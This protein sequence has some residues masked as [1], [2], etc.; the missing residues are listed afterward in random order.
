[1]SP[2]HA[3]PT[4]LPRGVLLLLAVLLAA[5]ASASA[6]AQS[7]ARYAPANPAAYLPNSI[8]AGGPAV[9]HRDGFTYVAIWRAFGDYVPHISRTDEATGLSE[10]AP[11]PGATAAPALPD[12]RLDGHY[13]IEMKLD[14]AGYIHAVATTHG[15]AFRYWRSNQPAS[16]AAGFTELTTDPALGIPQYALG[17]TYPKLL[18]DNNGVLFLVLRVEINTRDPDQ[19]ERGVA[20][21][22][23]DV[24]TGRWTA[25]GDYAFAHPAAV[26]GA[27]TLAGK[28]I[29]WEWAG[30]TP[31]L[32]YQGFS[33]N[34]SFDPQ[35]RLHFTVTTLDRFPD[36]DLPGGN[37]DTL[38]YARSD[39]GGDTW[40]RSDGT[41]ITRL[42][43]RGRAGLPDSAEIVYQGDPA[44]SEG[45]V[46]LQTQIVA[47]RADGLLIGCDYAASRTPAGWL[48]APAADALTAGR[49]ASRHLLGTD[50]RLHT[51]RAPISGGGNLRILDSVASD[52]A[53]QI[54]S[55]LPMP[56][57][58]GGDAP[59]FRRTGLLYGTLA[60]TLYARLALTPGW[61]Q[62]ALGSPGGHGYSTALAPGTFRIRS[63]GGSAA[64]SSDLGRFT[65]QT[66]SGDGVL[67]ARLDS[68][69][70]AS[71]A[72]AG[73]AFRENNNADARS[74][75]LRADASGFRFLVR[76]AASAVALP[77]GDALAPFSGS[78][79]PWLRLTRAGS[80]LSA[81]ASADGQTWTL[82][83]SVTL[84][85]PTDLLAGPVVS[86]GSA[87]P[88]DFAFSRVG[89][90]GLRNVAFGKPAAQSSNYYDLGAG[91][92]TDG[93]TDGNLANGSVAMTYNTDASYFWRVDLLEPATVR[94]LR[95]FK[96]TDGARDGQ[97]NNAN[98][99]LL[100][101]AGAALWTGSIP[102]GTL[103][104]PFTLTPAGTAGVPGVRFVE[105]LRSSQTALAELEVMGTDSLPLPASDLV[106]PATPAGLAVA[107]VNA[108]TVTLSWQPSASADVA[109]YVLQR[110][111][112]ASGP[113]VA[114]AADIFLPRYADTGR[115]ASVSAWHYR[116]AACDHAGNR[117]AFSSPVA[118]TLRDR[119]PPSPPVI[120]TYQPTD[121]GATLGWTDLAP[122]A[123][124]SHW[125]LVR[126]DRAGRETV[127]LARSTA[128]TY[129]WTAP[130]PG[131]YAEFFL[132]AY[133][134][135][136]NRSA[137]SNRVSYLSGAN[138]A[139]GRPATQGANTATAKLAVDGLFTDASIADLLAAN[140]SNPALN[141]WQVDLGSDRAIG[142]LE[143]HSRA[144]D[145]H[146]LVDF[147]VTVVN[148]AGQTVWSHR[149][150]TA[151]YIGRMLRLYP[152]GAAGRYVKVQ[153]RGS[154]IPVPY[155]LQLMEVRV[156]E[157]TA[158]WP[159]AS[160]P[161]DGQ[162]LHFDAS[163]VASLTREGYGVARWANLAPPGGA[164]AQPLAAARPRVGASP[165]LERHLLN[166][167]PDASGRWMKLKDA[168]AADWR[169]AGLR[170]VF[171][172]VKGANFLL[173]DGLAAPFHRGTAA[174]G[175]PD[176]TL[177]DAA[178]TDPAVRG[179]QTFLD[180]APVD[181][182][183]TPLPATYS[184]VSLVT[185]APVA[186]DRLGD[187]RATPGRQGGLQLAE[188]LAYDRPLSDAE[189]VR[190]ER[191]LAEKWNLGR[192]RA[193]V[194]AAPAGLVATPASHARVD[195][196]WTPVSGA[197][198]YLV[199]RATVSGGPYATVASGLA[200]TT[201]ADTGLSPSTAYHYVVSAAD[202]AGETPPGAE[203]TATTLPR[204]PPWTWTDLGATGLAGT[205]AQNGSAYTIAGAGAD[206]GG[207]AD[208]A[209]FAH[210]SFTGDGVFTARLVSRG[211]T[212]AGGKF[213]LAMRESLAAGAR[214]AS[215]FFDDGQDRARFAHRASVGGA[216]TLANA[217][218]T[219]LPPLWLRLA[220]T[221]NVFT[222]SWSTDGQAWTELGS[223][224]LALGSALQVGLISSSRNV[225]TLNSAVFD[226]VSGAG[227]DPPPPPSPTITVSGSPVALTATYG[228]ASSAPASFVVGGA[229]L[230]EGVSIVAPAGFELSLSLN[231]GYASALTAGAAG[232]FGPVTV[233]L[234]LAASTPAGSWSGEITLAS[235]G[236]T[237]LALAVPASVVAPVA[238]TVAAHPKSKA[239]GAPDPELTYAAEGLLT[240]DALSGALARAPGETPGVYAI[241]PG[242][243]SAGSNYQIG[244][245]GADFTILPPPP[246]PYGSWA[247]AKGLTSGLDDA[248]GAD[249]DG[250]GLANLGEFALA[251][252]PLAA[253]AARLYPS[254]QAIGG[255]KA[256][257]LTIPARTGAVFSGAGERV[258]APVDGLVYR[259]QGS[260]DLAGW[261]QA[262]EE[263]RGAT[264]EAARAG[265]P[266]L[267]AGW[268]YRSFAPAADFPR[269]FLRARVE[270]SA[271]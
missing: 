104:V 109:G 46:G 182:T 245:T 117:S 11:L 161:A 125:E 172:V 198:T 18:T 48:V 183:A 222:G 111:P 178:L 184:V 108:H 91:L 212:T 240:G 135:A 70:A 181:G 89:L 219:A 67:L 197:L 257:V 170:T 153:R 244:F 126:A 160:P 79:A 256:L 174:E 234:R 130:G 7:Y 186:A 133:D 80:L 190:V 87:S 224:T 78:A 110:A 62:A 215:V 140:Q 271:P 238:L 189:R 55:P 32:F 20:L 63:P 66:L 103:P 22:R 218:T 145:P 206:L 150:P 173:G 105:L 82:V 263:V 255:R 231:N 44:V 92:A 241:M 228:Q 192:G 191:H 201:F 211:T 142:A 35:N 13:S 17:S 185:S 139:L 252:E 1:M 29:F 148:S 138:L 75:L 53:R 100:D 61:H 209:H 56:D 171:W 149:Q 102:S 131:D 216:T 134:L 49:H 266:E 179:G 27:A 15:D 221:G 12:G 114:V 21:Y 243:L 227:W 202:L 144:Q 213:G 175:R 6:R 141:W 204:P 4:R 72:W 95:F 262:V 250:D 16:V 254:L 40:T 269:V 93:V 54:G 226:N 166:F 84:A 57:T 168:A 247:A 77:V 59:T 180:G 236:A 239:L 118:A 232:A 167:G 19:G 64:S 165:A 158:S 85:W 65:W 5:L 217:A 251:G 205:T 214:A 10:V 97:L 159:D 268:A 39:D 116:V 50:N 42:P 233:Y 122:A 34:L 235:P 81:H 259:V 25:L 203:A 71:S 94:T 143:L 41:P 107:S 74:A 237:T 14:P 113:F 36:A 128:T 2:S 68:F 248:P 112:S 3:T 157:K 96:R 177:W 208:A 37:G 242:T 210:V 176:A 230:S 258:S 26:R 99:R 193:V 162:V 154:T 69:P 264:A 151:Y 83:G 152:D 43:M 88:A 188:L 60:D 229:S 196:S 98:V 199:K 194:L 225:A 31:S 260:A 195:L 76:S 58:L 137:G 146:G 33:A 163:A 106:A 86:S 253:G 220:R 90:Q 9:V 47:D 119:L 270:P 45:V 24:H 164:F 28:A 207:T 123:D 38:V 120:T 121:T 115:A 127:V 169:P 155:P 246:T 136:G 30:Q 51:T 147:D 73:L 132:R 124:F 129:V 156:L 267:E 261:A 223:A 101:A 265:L 200:A 249:P 52:F 187:D 23:H 8:G